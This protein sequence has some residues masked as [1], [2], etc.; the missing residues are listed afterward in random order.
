M[1]YCVVLYPDSTEV[2][3]HDLPGEICIVAEDISILLPNS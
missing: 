3:R 2:P 1:Y